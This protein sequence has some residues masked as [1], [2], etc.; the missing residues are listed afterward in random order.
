MGVL[1]C[2]YI[3]FHSSPLQS[4]T[5]VTQLNLTDC[6]LEVE[7]GVAISTMLKENLYI[8]HLVRQSVPFSVTYIESCFKMGG[9]HQL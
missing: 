3:S 6:G 8:T 7:G 2:Y 1:A 9:G 4:N 5:C